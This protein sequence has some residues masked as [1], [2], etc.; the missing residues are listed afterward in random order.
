MTELGLYLGLLI[1]II[2]AI[3]LIIAAFRTS[4]LWGLAVLFLWP[5]SIFYVIFHWQ[6]A[7]G[8]FKLQVFGFLLLFVCALINEDGTS[9]AVNVI[10]SDGGYFGSNPTRNS[11]SDVTHQR[12]K[13]DG[14]QHCS[15]MH[16]RAE[17][18]FFIN[19]CPNTKMDGDHDGRPCEN[20]SRF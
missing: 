5:F 18:I 19:N 17:A 11:I 1:L 2:G 10:R 15:Q 9:S 7:K 13:C 4:I 14:R 16:S 20:D 6:E 12:F 3:G 8:A